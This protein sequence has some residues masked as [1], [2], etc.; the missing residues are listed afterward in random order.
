MLVLLLLLLVSLNNT[1]L[2]GKFST[3][4][5]L[6][7]RVRQENVHSTWVYCWIFTVWRFCMTF[8]SRGW[9]IDKVRWYSDFIVKSWPARLYLRKNKRCL[10]GNTKCGWLTMTYYHLSFS[11]RTYTT[12]H[13]FI[14][15]YSPIKSWRNIYSFTQ[16]FDPNFIGDLNIIS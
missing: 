4:K 3:S 13:Y 16:H 10:F 15:S 7:F 6:I 11:W 5:V 1:I 12:W 8:S 14:K 9:D 2:F